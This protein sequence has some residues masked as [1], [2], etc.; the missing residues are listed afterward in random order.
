MIKLE[1][2]RA[3]AAPPFD[4]VKDRVKMLVQRKK[5]QTYLEDLRKSA[6]MEKKCCRGHGAR[7]S[8]RPPAAASEDGTEEGVT[9]LRRSWRSGFSP[10]GRVL[11]GL[12]P[13]L[14]ELSS[15]RNASSSRTSTPNSCAFS[16][17]EPASAPATT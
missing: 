14:L 3:T 10:T 5:L 2:S 16:S 1:E 9:E 11:V 4:E 8:L 13:D 12:N 17:F 15:F 7:A 6:K